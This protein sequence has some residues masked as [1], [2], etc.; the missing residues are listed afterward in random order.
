MTIRNCGSVYSINRENF[1]QV[2]L[3]HKFAQNLASDQ[4]FIS[5]EMVFET[6]F[7]CTTT[8]NNSVF[9]MKLL[10]LIHSNYNIAMHS[11][12]LMNVNNK[13]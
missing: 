12:V 2:S 11:N 13:L 7:G 3:W 6:K 1:H 8:K 10:K 4:M 5:S 9:L